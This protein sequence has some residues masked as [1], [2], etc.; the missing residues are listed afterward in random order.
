ML[1][2]GSGLGLPA[3]V[4]SLA[5]AVVLSSEID[6]MPANRSCEPATCG[7]RRPC[8]AAASAWSWSA[9]ALPNLVASR[10]GSVA[11][12]GVLADVRTVPGRVRGVAPLA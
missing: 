6:R 3:G 4:G 11:T 5:F 10:A 7:R 8:A 12:F 1:K 2:P 9:S